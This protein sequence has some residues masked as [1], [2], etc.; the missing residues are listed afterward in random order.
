MNRLWA[1]V[2]LPVLLILGTP[3]AAQPGQ[4]RHMNVS[5]AAETATVQ[6]S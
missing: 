3:A 5:L 6:P 2:L 1:L 4:S